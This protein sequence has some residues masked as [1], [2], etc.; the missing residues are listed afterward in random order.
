MNK[1]LVEVYVPAA[2]KTFDV[3]IPLSIQIFEVVNLIAIQ[4]E[5]LSEGQF[6]RSINTILCYRE[7]GRLL[8]INSLVSDSD[9][10]NGTK[11]LLI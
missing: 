6:K 4:V 3:F 1:F 11:L 9:I 10:K 5:A 7:D 8:D 2:N